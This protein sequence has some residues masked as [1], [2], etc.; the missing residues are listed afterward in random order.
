M[1]KADKPKNFRDLFPELS[2]KELQ[3][4]EENLEAYL[5]VVLRIFER[6]ESDPVAYAEFKKSLAEQKPKKRS[7][8]EPR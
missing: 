8:K 4:A 7:K 1:Q 3:E 2:E 6:I 5:E